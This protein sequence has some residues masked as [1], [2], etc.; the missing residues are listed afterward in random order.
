MNID[1]VKMRIELDSG[2]A[3]ELVDSDGTEYLI[4]EKNGRFRLEPLDDRY[5]FVH[6]FGKDHSVVADVEAIEMA[7]DEEAWL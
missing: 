1:V 5:V 7:E 2:E 3:V 4:T 6:V